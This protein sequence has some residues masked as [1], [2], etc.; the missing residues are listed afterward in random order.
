MAKRKNYQWLYLILYLVFFAV[1]WYPLRNTLKNPEPKQVPYSEFLEDVRAGKV[2]EVRI[3]QATVTATLK[4]EAGK[5]DEPHE[6]TAVRIPGIDET[7]LLKE[8][9][10][11]HVTFSGHIDQSGWWVNALS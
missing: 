6:I 1:I 4:P 5:K 3:D 9:E 11:Q 8:L 10:A 7:D 2:S